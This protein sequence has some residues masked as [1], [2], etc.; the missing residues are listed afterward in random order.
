MSAD[1]GRSAADVAHDVGDAAVA[2]GQAVADGVGAA[3]DAW[4][5][6]DPNHREGIH[7]ALDIAGFVP[8]IGEVADVANGVLYLA[9]GDYVNAG[10]SF[11]SA[12]PLAGDTAKGGRA[13][14]KGAKFADAAVSI[15]KGAKFADSAVSAY[16][17]FEVASTAWTAADLSVRAFNVGST[18]KLSAGAKG[19]SLAPAMSALQGGA[20]Y[21]SKASAAPTGRLLDLFG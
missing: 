6:M 8:V 14:T 9:E 10:I 17:A 15:S 4:N 7:L 5:N 3:A 16:K 19:L 20:S 2:G 1:L 11:V 18:G 12:I 13:V 21:L